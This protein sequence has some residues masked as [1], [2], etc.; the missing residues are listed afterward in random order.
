MNRNDQKADSIPSRGLPCSGLLLPVYIAY[1]YTTLDASETI[2]APIIIMRFTYDH[3]L[4]EKDFALVLGGQGGGGVSRGITW[5][6][7]VLDGT[8]TEFIKKRQISIGQTT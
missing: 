1:T 2:A 7:Y 6:Q 4:F 5:L 8:D 3:V